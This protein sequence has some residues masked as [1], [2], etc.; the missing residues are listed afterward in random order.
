MGLGMGYG[1]VAW[2]TAVPTRHPRANEAFTGLRFNNYGYVLRVSLYARRSPRFCSSPHRTP[3]G[4]HRVPIHLARPPPVPHCSAVRCTLP[5]LPAP[6]PARL[7]SPYLKV[8]IPQQD[9]QLQL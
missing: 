2:Q 9:L 6:P 1:V 5:A 3:H 7:S 4:P 8:H